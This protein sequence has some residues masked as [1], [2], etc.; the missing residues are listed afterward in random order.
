M[1]KFVYPFWTIAIIINSLLVIGY[2]QQDELVKRNAEKIR[3]RERLRANER[4]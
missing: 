2:Y 4:V 3:A 1:K